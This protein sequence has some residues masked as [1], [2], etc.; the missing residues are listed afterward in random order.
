ML[1]GHRLKGSIRDEAYCKKLKTMH[2]EYVQTM[3]SFRNN[4]G[5][6]RG[7]LAQVD[8]SNALLELVSELAPAL[9]PAEAE[10]VL[11]KGCEEKDV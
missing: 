5:D 4:G 7:L 8:N 9:K 3:R 10:S 1:T 6:I 11:E 2:N